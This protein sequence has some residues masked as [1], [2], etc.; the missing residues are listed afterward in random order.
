MHHSGK[1]DIL[2]VFLRNFFHKRPPDRPPWP[3]VRRS[4][5]LGGRADMIQVSRLDGPKGQVY[6]KHR[7][8]KEAYCMKEG[9]PVES[10]HYLLMKAHSILNKQ[11]STAA[12]SIGLSPG[13]PKI[14]EYLLL[15]GENNQKTIADYCEIEQ[16]TVGSI[17]LRMENAGLVARTNRPPNRRSLYVALTPAGK[18]AAEHVRRIFAEQEE[19]AGAEMTAEEILQLRT[20]LD[21][22]CRTA[23]RRGGEPA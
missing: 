4:S 1:P 16:A 10:L 23:V 9:I 7:Y 17:L 3:P 20:L 14:L 21:K 11:I 19:K 6:N 8:Y 18:T 22:F 13:Q 15:W 2:T 12:G 5:A